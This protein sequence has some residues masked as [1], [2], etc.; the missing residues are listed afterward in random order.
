MTSSKS[1]DYQEQAAQ[2][3]MMIGRGKRTRRA[4]GFDEIALVPGSLTI[5]PELCDVSMKLSYHKFE[6]PIIASAMDSVVDARMAI[7]MGKLG[8]LAVLNLQGLQ[9]RYEDVSEAYEMV[10]SCDNNS[11]VEVM[12]KLYSKPVSEALIAKRVEE[13]KKGGVIVA[14]SVTPNFAEKYGPAAVEA[15]LGILVVQSTVT[16]LDHR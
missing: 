3:G 16:G 15:G 8:G 10:V 9:T 14:A 13:I 11:F 2:A 7:E 12:Q 4:Y 6:M 1:L 5:D